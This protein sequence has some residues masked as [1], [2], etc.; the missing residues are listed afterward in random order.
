MRETRCRDNGYR[1][2]GLVR[3]DAGVFV[4]DLGDQEG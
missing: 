1:K 2:E 3:D 4:G